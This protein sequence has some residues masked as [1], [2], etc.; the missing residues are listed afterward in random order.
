MWSG[1]TSVDDQESLLKHGKSLMIAVRMEKGPTIML[2]SGAWF[3]FSNPAS[4]NFTIEDVAHG[5][6]NICR[7]AGQCRRFYSV[8]EHSMLVSETAVGFELEA[9]LHD[10]AEAFMGDITRPLKQMLPEYKNIENGVEEAILMRFGLTIPLPLGIKDADLRV[11][12]AEQ[13]QIM[14]RGTDDWARE[15]NVVPAP[16]IVRHLGPEE[17]KRAFLD[18]YERLHRLQGSRQVPNSL[19]NSAPGATSGKR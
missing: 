5:L 7:Y 2:Q 18:R 11:L 1:P 15:Q 3:D 12:A 14:P 13:S 17:A 19:G 4:S 6:A 8:A 10:A 9:L 16:I